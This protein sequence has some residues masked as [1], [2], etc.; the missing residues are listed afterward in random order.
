MA[1]PIPNFIAWVRDNLASL[2]ESFQQTANTIAW[3]AP[4]QA[5]AIQLSLSRAEQQHSL[6]IGRD[7]DADFILDEASVSRQHA[8]LM[9]AHGSYVIEDLGSTNGTWL[10]G[11]QIRRARVVPGDE[12][13]FGYCAVSLVP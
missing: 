9:Y 11:E 7:S 8:K 2:D 4:R 13:C 10:N 6:S 5:G 1:R 3:R 12:I